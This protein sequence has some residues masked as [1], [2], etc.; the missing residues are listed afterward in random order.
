MLMIRG[1]DLHPHFIEKKVLGRRNGFP[2]FPETEFELN[3]ASLYLSLQLLLQT[4]FHQ[5][6]V[7]LPVSS[8]F[9]TSSNIDC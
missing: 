7:S 9:L 3:L 6:E 1:Y 2:S 8:P 5:K 4:L